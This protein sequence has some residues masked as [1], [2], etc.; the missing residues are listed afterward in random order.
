VHFSP[1]FELI[2][3]EPLGLATAAIGSILWMC[4]YILAIRRGFLEKTYAIPAAAIFGNFT[5]EFL[6]AF[7]FPQ[8]SPAQRLVNFIWFGL[9]VV[10]VVTYLL[11]GKKH[12][13][14]NPSLFYP[15]FLLGIGTGVTLFATASVQ[16]S[17]F[18]GNYS[19]FTL[20]LMMSVLFIEMLTRRKSSEGQSIYIAIFKWF[21]TFG[22]AILFTIRHPDWVY[23]IALFILIFI[24]DLIYTVML[25]RQLKREGI[26]PFKRF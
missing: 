18:S 13:A 23:L 20:N 1:E 19:G 5:W 14:L 25:Y 26:A 8:S 22:Y 24:Y 11:Y 3:L 2:A 17:D 10:I 7:V 15:A 21:G 9:D 6:F 4:A 12:F 16:L